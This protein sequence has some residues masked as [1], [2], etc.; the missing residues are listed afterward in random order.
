MEESSPPPP[1]EGGNGYRT[2]DPMALR[3]IENDGNGVKQGYNNKNI[4]KEGHNNNKVD[5][6]KGIIS[7]TNKLNI[8]NSN[9]DISKKNLKDV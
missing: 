2:D 1:K 5:E 3:L 6:N 8:N 9:L 4:S 7:K